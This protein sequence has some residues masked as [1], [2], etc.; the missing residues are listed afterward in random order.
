MPKTVIALNSDTGE[1]FGNFKVGNDEELMKFISSANIACGFHAGDP[2]VMAH[3]VRLARDHGVSIGA[4]PGYPDLMGFGRRRMDVAPEEMKNY[5]IY[6]V[7]ALKAFV[8]GEGLQLRHVWLHG[9]LQSAAGKDESLARAIVEG[10]KMVDPKLIVASRPTLLSYQMAAKEGLRTA[11]FVGVD[12]EYDRDGMPVIQRK[13]KQTDPKEAAKKAVRIAKE[14]TLT[15]TTGEEIVLKANA[16]LVHGDTPNAIDVL[17]EIRNEFKKEGIE[18][19][20]LEKT[21]PLWN[22]RTT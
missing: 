12:T 20:P 18:V 8:E 1:S 14:G 19:V 16:V 4:H 17:K 21:F 10:I 11:V 22:G 13:K 6:Q 15:A 5:I 2:V 9:A 7:G 3:T